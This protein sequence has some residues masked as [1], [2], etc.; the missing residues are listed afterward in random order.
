MLG[1]ISF[2][3]PGFALGTLSPYD[4]PNV[5]KAFRLGFHARSAARKI[6]GW[7]LPAALA[8]ALVAVAIRH[9]APHL[10]H[11]IADPLFAVRAA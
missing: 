10:H 8:L 6:A 7:L 3:V 11:T 9:F 2:Y 5:C 4:G 1:S